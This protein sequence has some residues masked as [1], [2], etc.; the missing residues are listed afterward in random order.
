MKSCSKGTKLEAGQQHY[1]T[2]GPTYQDPS[3]SEP[4]KATV[5]D[6]YTVVSTK[7]PGE[8]TAHVKHELMTLTVSSQSQTQ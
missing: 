2:G 7:K 5:G 4:Q 3:T 6:A 8:A 1:P